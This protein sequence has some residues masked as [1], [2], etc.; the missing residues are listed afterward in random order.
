MT[1]GSITESS[2]EG[3]HHTPAPITHELG[4]SWNLWKNLAKQS[5]EF[6]HP[7]VFVTIYL[8]KAG[9]FLQQLLGKTLISNRIFH[10]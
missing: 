1:N 5:D 3:D 10:D 6:G 4:G 9:L 7:E 8:M 2:T